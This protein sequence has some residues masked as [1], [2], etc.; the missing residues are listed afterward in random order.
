[1]P[2][3][4]EAARSV[5]SRSLLALSQVLLSEV[6]GEAVD[7]RRCLRVDDHLHRHIS[8]REGCRDPCART[9]NEEHGGD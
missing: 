1:M 3:P 2:R 6:A 8:V 4:M 7:V 5:D 9:Q